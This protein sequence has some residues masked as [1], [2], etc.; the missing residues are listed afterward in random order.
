MCGRCRPRHRAVLRACGADTRLPSARAA[1]P[2]CCGFWRTCRMTTADSA[3]SSWIGAAGGIGPDGTSYAGGPAWQA[4]A[5]HALACGVAT[6]RRRRVG[7]ALSTRAAL[8]R[9]RPCR[10][11]TCARYA[12]WRCWSTGARR[13]IRRVRRSR[14]RLVARNRRH[15]SAVGLLNAAGERAD[16]FVGA[17]AGAALADTGQAARPAGP[18]GMCA[19]ERGGAV[20]AGRRLRLRLRACA[21]IRRELYGRRP[22]GGGAGYRRTSATAAAA[23]VR[24]WFLGRNAAVGRSTTPGGAW[25]STASTTAA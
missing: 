22:G 21:A 8:D 18:G 9:R 3:T 17:P 16:S 25:C 11:W 14:P 6:V 15:A 1:A 7:R 5:L 23:A 24:Q 4:R 2:G 13:A 20:A 12:C 19:R 10:T